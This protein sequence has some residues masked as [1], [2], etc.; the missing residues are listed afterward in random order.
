MVPLDKYCSIDTPE[1]SYKINKNNNIESIYTVFW[2]EF[3]IRYGEYT[4]TVDS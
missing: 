1:I 4:S 3:H 2:V